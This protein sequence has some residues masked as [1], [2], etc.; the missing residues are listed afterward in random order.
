MRIMV[1][2]II[3]YHLKDDCDKA[4]VKEGMKTNLEGLVGKVPNLLNMKI[5][6]ENL[7]DGN[8]DVMLEATFSDAKAM[9][10]YITHPEHVYVAKT[11]VRPYIASKHVFNN[12]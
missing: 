11:F 5:H 8:S 10:D 9:E 3:I 6:T 1:R 2:R 7:V 12:D 4:K